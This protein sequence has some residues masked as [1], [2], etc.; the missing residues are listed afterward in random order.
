MVGPQASRLLPR[1]GPAPHRVR[2]LA[3]SAPD[4]GRRR[5]PARRRRRERLS[6]LR[7]VLHGEDL[8]LELRVAATLLLL[9]AQ[10]VTRLRRLRVEDIV[11]TGEAT[12][13]RF[14]ND[15][16]P[17]PS[18]VADLILRYVRARPNMATAANADSPWLFPGYRP[19]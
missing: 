19:G 10:P 14:G 15:S 6:L 1:K 13:I 9:Y 7:R 12:G 2:D 5:P 4:A 16:A 17:L 8:P 11:I 3:S 18:P